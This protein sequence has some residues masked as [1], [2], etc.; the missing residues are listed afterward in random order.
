MHCS[1]LATSFLRSDFRSFSG[2]MAAA[3]LGGSALLALPAQAQG[4]YR[5]VG[6]D[7]R[8]TFSDRPPISNAKE[9]AAGNAGA[10]PSAS[11]PPLAQLPYELRQTATRYPVTLYAA[12]ECQPCDEA[13]NYLQGRGVPFSE[14]T[15]ETNADLDA[16]KK[17]SGQENLP[18]ATIGSQ[19]L[20][21]FGEENWA[22]YLKAA[23]YPTQSALPA[24]YR[25]P[26]AKPLTTP[27]PAEK[28]KS[29]EAAARHSAPAATH[30]TPPPGTPTPNNPAGLRF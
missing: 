6:A 19:H 13:R 27:A 26:A 8:V 18:F 17:L 11:T 20:K 14:R 29:A 21:G 15:V 16:L 1:F 22:Q 4:V 30:A 3:L 25:A 23:G 5:I 28:A 9:S 10:A 24:S 2:L 12:K 7:G